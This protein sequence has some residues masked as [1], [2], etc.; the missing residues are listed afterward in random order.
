MSVK[1]PSLNVL[2]A[3]EATVRLSSMSAAADELS[4]THGAVSRHIKSLEDMFGIA[5]LIRGA[6]AV[7][8]TPEGSRLASELSS[9]FA[10]IDSAVE[11]LQTGPLTL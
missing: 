1:R 9:A 11:Q 3:F 6:R 8:A 7:H 5:L 4:V 2:R 10:M